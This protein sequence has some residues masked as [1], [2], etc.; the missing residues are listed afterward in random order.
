MRRR[1]LFLVFRL[2]SFHKLLSFRV[3]R[4][5]ATRSTSSSK[6]HH[7]QLSA[8]KQLNRQTDRQTRWL[9]YWSRTYCQLNASTLYD[10]I[11]DVTHSAPSLRPC[12]ITPVTYTRSHTRQTA[13]PAQPSCLRLGRPHRHSDITHRVDFGVKESISH[14][15]RRACYVTLRYVRHHAEY[16][17][18]S[19]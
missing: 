14:R 17:R 8:S 6:Q 18:N 12:V 4:S 13:P 10:I 16:A 2:W 5:L 11:N 19:L 15:C 3:Q 7:A 9:S 1:W